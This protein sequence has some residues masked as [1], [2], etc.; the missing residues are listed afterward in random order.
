MHFRS[1]VFVF[2]AAMSISL[3]AAAPFA[4]SAAPAPGTLTTRVTCLS[5]QLKAVVASDQGGMMHRELHITLTNKGNTPCA[6]DGYASI[7]LLDAGKQA[8]LTAENFSGT[9][10][11]F[12]LAAGKQ[13]SFGIRIA[14]SNGVAVY[15]TVPLL[16]IIPPGDVVP[17]ILT[18]PLPTGPVIDIQPIVAGP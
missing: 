14:T 16:A 2:A 17:L 6:L 11:P 8:Q 13:A 5:S 18:H 1:F 15:P 3:A 4:A 7:R 12:V 9:P 10:H